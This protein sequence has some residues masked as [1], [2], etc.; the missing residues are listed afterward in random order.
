MEYVG[1]WAL[2]IEEIFNDDKSI[3]G[4]FTYSN[5]NLILQLNGSFEDF[6]GSNDFKEHPMIY[7]FTQNGHLLILSRCMVLNCSLS[8][9]GY[10]TCRYSC[11]T[12]F[13]FKNID[14][15]NTSFDR[16][17]MEAN[18]LENY[19]ENT[20]FEK[21]LSDNCL[22]YSFLCKHNSDKIA[23]KIKD[24]EYSIARS[25]ITNEN[26]KD[27]NYFTCRSKVLIDCSNLI[28]DKNSLIDFYYKK[29]L[30]DENIIVK[31]FNLLLNRLVLMK[32]IKLFSQKRHIASIYDVRLDTELDNKIS[33]IDKI[34]LNSEHIQKSIKTYIEKYDKYS[35]IINSLTEYIVS[36]K[37]E[38]KLK[39]ITS[40]INL[41]GVLEDYYRN[42]IELTPTTDNKRFDEMLSV[43]SEKLNEEENEW[44]KNTLKYN[45]QISFRQIISKLFR[46]V[47]NLSNNKF[48]ELINSKKKSSLINK[49]Y[50]SRNWH[51]HYGSN[52]NILKESEL[53]YVT[54]LMW[55]CLRYLL[56]R[57]FDV[58][59]TA[60]NNY[61]KND[62]NIAFLIKELLNHN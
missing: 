55:I 1:M 7:G 10:E 42:I 21:K 47:D 51:T 30:Y 26:N 32:E 29:L 61:I 37:H 2:S 22:D 20:T 25:W 57:D 52:K 23:F 31:F 35:N 24:R 50:H 45:N 13:D 6:S 11:E 54:E 46:D 34:Y 8:I 36:F 17:V 60:L 59:L 58:D 14:S 5:K 15:L 19:L 44:L 56:L 27:S 12:C 39:P 40:F 33:N 38:K 62:N 3:S 53:V 28:I 41:C 16:I 49:I 9:P 18:A 48:S 4:T 43:I